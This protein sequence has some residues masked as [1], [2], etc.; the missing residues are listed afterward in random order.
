MSGIKR[1]A[2]FSEEELTV[3]V[4]EVKKRER[5]IFG[6]L[7]RQ[8]TTQDK[9]CA[10]SQVAVAVSG[11]GLCS[12]QQADVRKKFQDLKSSVK[13]KLAENAREMRKTGGGECDTQPLTNYEENLSTLL[14]S[15]SV[16]GIAGISDA[17][18]D[19]T[20]EEP[21]CVTEEVVMDTDDSRVLNVQESGE[22]S[23]SPIGDQFHPSCLG[24]DYSKAS[25]SSTHTRK[26]QMTAEHNTT[27][28]V[29][30]LHENLIDVVHKVPAA[31]KDVAAEVH[32]GN[33]SLKEVVKEV[34]D[35]N[36]SLNVISKG[37][38]EL[39]ECMKNN[40]AL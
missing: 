2:N 35:L 15:T 38:W 24:H 39:V 18:Q 11:V 12:R 10:W 30:M 26:K 25:V 7:S 29:L 14:S 34:Q 27:Q 32:E 28:Q 9:H 33:K 20:V 37:I 23:A 6:K 17:G 4:D 22:P 31:L 13:K 19:Y 3:L 36:K 8:V 40:Q 16:E 5:I 1:K 21:N